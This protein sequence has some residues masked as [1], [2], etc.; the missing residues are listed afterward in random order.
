[1]LR[2]IGLNLE[3]AADTPEQAILRGKLSLDVHRAHQAGWA[4]DILE[5]T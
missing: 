1:M 2:E 3:H 5:A 4:V